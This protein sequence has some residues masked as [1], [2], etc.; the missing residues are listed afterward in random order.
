MRKIFDK[1][2][3]VHMKEA[4]I[5]SIFP[6]PVYWSKLE[7]PFST[8]EQKYFTDHNDGTNLRANVGNT[9]SKNNYILNL[10]VFASLKKELL[11]SVQDYFDKIICA[12]N[13]KPWIT[14]SWLNYTQPNQ[15]HHQHAHPNALV[16]GVF[17]INADKEND[18]IKFY[19]R[20]Y[21]R[22]KI[23]EVTSYNLH[24][25]ESW[26]FSVE[27]YD[28]IL[29]PSSLTHAVEQKVG[30]NTRTS[31]AFNVFVKGRLGSNTSLTEL[32]L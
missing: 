17:Y 14:Q 16:S 18:R 3:P 10:P 22:I 20:E 21:E 31:L 30:N 11:N 29:F 12:K 23:E 6:T 24:N 1:Q 15:F 7:R 5:A 25:S 8:K 4:T 13:I 9:A 28:L 27:S 26:W 2:R 32:K 19:K